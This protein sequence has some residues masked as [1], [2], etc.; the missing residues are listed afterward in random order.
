MGEARG[1]QPGVRELARAEAA[2]EEDDDEAEGP[3]DAGGAR[4]EQWVVPAGDGLVELCPNA[5][6]TIAAISPL[7][8]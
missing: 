6:A 4:D 1:E 7:L 3:G 5:S 8:A 2:G